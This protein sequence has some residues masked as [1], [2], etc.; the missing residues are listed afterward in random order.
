[1]PHFAVI[2][3]MVAVILNKVIFT[4]IVGFDR[5]NEV[6]SFPSTNEVR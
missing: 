4:K 5:F 3:N 1:M 6:M 2:I